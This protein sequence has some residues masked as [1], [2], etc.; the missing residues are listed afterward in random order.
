MESE[1]YEKLD[2]IEIEKL[3]LIHNI[4]EDQ[5]IEVNIPCP[6]LVIERAVE[7]FGHRI[8]LACYLPGSLIDESKKMKIERKEKIPTS[9]ID[10]IKDYIKK[11]FPK[12]FSNLNV[13]YKEIP[14]HKTIVIKKIGVHPSFFDVKHPLGGCY[15]LKFPSAKEKKYDF[16]KK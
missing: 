3:K 15:V 7:E 4:W 13:N 6:E 16:H 9:I 1:G 2:E 14:I 11:K 12:I 10:Y 8:I 5:F